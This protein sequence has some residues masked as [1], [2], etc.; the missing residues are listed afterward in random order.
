MSQI[1]VPDWGEVRRFV[2]EKV[3]LHSIPVPESGCWLWEMT[4]NHKGYGYFGPRPYK[5]AHRA[6]YFGFHGDFDKSL[7]ICHRCDTPS[8]VNPDH[9]FAGTQ[10]QNMQDAVRKGRL[11]TAKFDI[12]KRGHRFT[13]ENTRWKGGGLRSRECIECDR[14]RR[15]TPEYREKRRNR[16]AAKR[17]ALTALRQ[18]KP[19]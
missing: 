17:A 9:L 8:C 4:L 14:Q 2:R 10:K 16:N 12:C 1:E 5:L 7:S 18:E 13:P 15:V 6:S 11:K 3:L 19:E